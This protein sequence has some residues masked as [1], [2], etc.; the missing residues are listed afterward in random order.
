[1]NETNASYRAEAEAMDDALPKATG[2]D[3]EG[4]DRFRSRVAAARPAA[5]RCRRAGACAERRSDDARHPDSR[6]ERIVRQSVS[7]DA[8]A[9]AG[10]EDVSERD[11]AGEDAPDGRRR[12]RS[13]SQQYIDAIAKFIDSYDRN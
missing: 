8:P 1:M 5:V 6:G 12:R 2:A 4:M 9:V 13:P 10:G 7:Q 11:T 3:A